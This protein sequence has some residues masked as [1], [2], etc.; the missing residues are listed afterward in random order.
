MPVAVR[1]GDLHHDSFRSVLRFVD[2]LVRTARDYRL[3]RRALLG[4]VAFHKPDEGIP[5]GR[6][7]RLFREL[8]RC[9]N[10]DRTVAHLNGLRLSV[11]VDCEGHIIAVV[12]AVYGFLFMKGIGFPGGQFRLHLETASLI[13][14]PFRHNGAFPVNDL[15]HRSGQGLPGFGVNLVKLY[16]RY[17]IL[18]D[19]AVNRPV[20]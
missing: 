6:L 5:A 11:C 3:A 9:H 10:D 12:I 4:L 16:V 20:F 15:E 2:H 13:R 18:H 7:H 8:L 14:S 1:V 19:H 17:S